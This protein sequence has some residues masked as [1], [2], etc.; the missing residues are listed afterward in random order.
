MYVIRAKYVQP[1]GVGYLSRWGSICRDLFS[2][3][4]YPTEADAW[5]HLANVPI[6]QGYDAQGPF[7]WVE[8]IDAAPKV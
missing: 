2:A 6:L 5:S 8:S 1:D 3:Q 4:K 7:A